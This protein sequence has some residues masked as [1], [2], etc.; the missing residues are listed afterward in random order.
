MVIKNGVRRK[1]HE[2]Q[3]K[4]L[5]LC[6]EIGLLR[7]LYLYFSKNLSFIYLVIKFHGILSPESDE[8]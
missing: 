4:K 7:P 1:L 6:V 5:L 3:G 8:M 2:F